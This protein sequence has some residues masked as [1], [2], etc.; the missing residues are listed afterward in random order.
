MA[1]DSAALIEKWTPISVRKCITYLSYNTSTSTPDIKEALLP[2][3]KNFSL[4]FLNMRETNQCTLAKL[5]NRLC[6]AIIREV[7]AM[8]FVPVFLR[9]LLLHVLRGH[10]HEF[11]DDCMQQPFRF[12]VGKCSP[13]WWWFQCRPAMQ[14]LTCLRGLCKRFVWAIHF[15]HDKSTFL[16]ATSKP[17]HN[18]NNLLRVWHL[19][20]VQLPS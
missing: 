15:L 18:Q 19:K 6:F 7:G 17:N 12:V 10:L 9:C 8:G 16:L 14:Q 5:F 3:W 11:F 4:T 1:E 20:A 13:I 2:C